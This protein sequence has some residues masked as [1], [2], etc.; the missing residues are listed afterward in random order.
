[1][2]LQAVLKAK[3][4]ITGIGGLRVPILNTLFVSL[5]GD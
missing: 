3:N 1:M 5:I 2:I 4:K